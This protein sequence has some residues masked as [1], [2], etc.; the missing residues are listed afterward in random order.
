MKLFAVTGNE[1][2]RIRLHAVCGPDGPGP[3]SVRG[4]SY[5]LRLG[6][7]SSG[8]VGLDGDSIGTSPFSNFQIFN[9]SSHFVE[10]H[11]VA[12]IEPEAQRTA[13]DST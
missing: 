12:Y 1:T 6:H 4:R 13:Q 9:S 8:I 2:V 7:G 10:L 11:K 5:Q 3:P